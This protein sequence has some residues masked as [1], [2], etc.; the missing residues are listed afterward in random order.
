MAEIVLGNE[1]YAQKGTTSRVVVASRS[2]VSFWPDSSTSPGIYGCLFVSPRN[3][4]DQLYPRSVG[5]FSVVSYDSQGCGGGIRTRLHTGRSQLRRTEL[6]NDWRS[7][8][9]SICFGAQPTLYLW[10]DIISRLKV[11][12]GKLLSCLCRAPS[13]TRGR[14]CHLC[15]NLQ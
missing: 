13:L 9:Q 5:S 3:R 14:V 1:T 6:R 15:L 11:S 10:P 8:S 2:K 7:V 12:A 4:M